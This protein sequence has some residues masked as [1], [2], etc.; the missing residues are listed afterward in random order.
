MHFIRNLIPDRVIEVLVSPIEYHFADIFTKSLTKEK[1]SILLS[2]LIF[3]EVVIK[4]G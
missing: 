3:Q 2:K 4:G 1:F